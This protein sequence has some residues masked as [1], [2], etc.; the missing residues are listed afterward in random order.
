[1]QIGEEEQANG[2]RGRDGGEQA[3]DTLRSGARSTADR[4]SP[5]AGAAGRVEDVSGVPLFGTAATTSF[6]LDVILASEWYSSQPVT[7]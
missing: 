7:A 1:M 6:G 4:A 5:P 2:Q 3:A